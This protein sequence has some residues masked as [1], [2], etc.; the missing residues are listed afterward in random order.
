MPEEK[1]SRRER[2]RQVSTAFRLTRERDPRLVPYMLLALVVVAGVIEGLGVLAGHLYLYLV[3]AVILGVLAAM[4]IF[5]RRAQ[6]A[7]YLQAEG[8]PGAAL[9]VLKSLRGDWRT[10]EG[11]AGNT[12]LDAV[13]R[14]IGK[15]GVVL[16]GEGAPH[17]VRGLLAQEKK[18]VARVAGETPIYDI[19]IGTDDDQVPLK[20]LQSYL[21]RL[22]RNIDGKQ[23]GALDKRLQALATP[24]AA[25]PKGPLPTKAQ[26]GFNERTIRRR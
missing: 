24:R 20:K 26:R 3:P 10:T 5:G 16:I 7:A 4:I 21:L 18:R 14:V 11:V 17:R 22:P 23:I 9:W 8:Q 6:R 12:Q 1:L 25:M 13:H 15:P 2:F 19:V